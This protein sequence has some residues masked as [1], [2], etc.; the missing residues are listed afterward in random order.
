MEIQMAT[1]YIDWR[2]TAEHHGI[3]TAGKNDD[4]IKAA[5]AKIAATLGLVPFKFRCA[6][7]CT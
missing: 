4:E 5:L 7:H 2:A 6:S 3:N 1:Y